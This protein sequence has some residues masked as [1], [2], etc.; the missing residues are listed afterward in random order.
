M[1]RVVIVQA[2]LGSTR[3]PGKVLMDLAGRPMLTQILRRLASCKLVDDV[4]VATTDSPS[5][6]PIV[7]AARHADA[8]C[9]R[10][11]EHDVLSR[12][13][14][15]A[16]DARADVIVRV[17]ADC[18]LI[19]PEVTDAVIEALCSSAASV[20]YV[21]NVIDRTY[22]RGLDVEALFRDVLERVDRRGRSP[23]AREHVTHF[24]LRE[25]PNLF[26][27]HS[28]VDRVDNSDLRWTVD[29]PDDLEMARRLYADLDLGDRICSYREVLAHV[30]ANPE[31]VALNARVRQ[32]P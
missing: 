25:H 3:L 14:G 7:A 27:C 24:I 32:K 29:E 28:V 2:R 4:I 13:A 23:E 12:Y 26:S 17:T 15:A 9:F 1:R 11:S 6:D 10:G 5:D 21:S 30:R 31:I 19:D 22:P 16:R 18:P 8:G 20:D